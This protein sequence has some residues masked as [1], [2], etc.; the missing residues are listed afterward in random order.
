MELHDVQVKSVGS[1]IK[2][3]GGGQ[4]TALYDSNDEVPFN[5]R[6]V[7]DFGNLTVSETVKLLQ[8][9]MLRYAWYLE[10]RV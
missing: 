5:D 4:P 6:A 3:S 2:T 9:N 10:S 1:N 7:L 8:R